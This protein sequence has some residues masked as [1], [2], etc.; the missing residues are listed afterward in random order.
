[1]VLRLSLFL[2]FLFS[3]VAFSAGMPFLIREELDGEPIP[4]ESPEDTFEPSPLPS[5]EVTLTTTPSP[6]PSSSVSDD[7][8]PAETPEDEV[9]VEMSYLSRVPS[10]HLVHASPFSAAVLCPSSST[11]PCATA[12]HMVRVAGKSISYRQLCKSTNCEKRNMLVNSVLAHAWTE[13]MHDGNT[14]LTMF[15]ARHPEFVQR[16]VHRV[17]S[18]RRAIIRPFA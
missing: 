3:L 12:D 8:D 4:S 18:M 7:E 5:D 14:A 13:T 2:A 6:S 15:D 11:L 10:E 1:M 9:C 16:V 17:I